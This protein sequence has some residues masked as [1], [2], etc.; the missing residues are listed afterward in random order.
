[1]LVAL[2]VGIFIAPETRRRSG[3]RF[4]IPGAITLG[5]GVG[6]LLLAVNRGISWGW[7]NPIVLTAAIVAPLSLALFVR[8]ETRTEAPL[9]PPALMRR[10]A[11]TRP[12]LA[13]AVRDLAM[14]G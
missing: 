2:V 9:L 5:V 4:D 1:M 13:Q 11:F 12:M 3:I 8:V 14:A 6:S 7:S 10:R